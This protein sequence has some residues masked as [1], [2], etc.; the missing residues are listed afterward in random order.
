MHDVFP[1]SIAVDVGVLNNKTI[2][3]L[4]NSRTTFRQTATH[5]VMQA[6]TCWEAALALATQDT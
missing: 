5:S 1:C 4:R 3:Q 6:T 2:G